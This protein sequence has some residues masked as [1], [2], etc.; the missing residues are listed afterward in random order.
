MSVSYNRGTMSV[1]GQPATNPHAAA[2]LLNLTPDSLCALLDSWG[3]PGYRA[4]QILQ[5]VYENGVASYDPMANLPKRLRVRL[6]EELPIYGSTV[7]WRRESRDG[8]VKLL[9]AW[10]DG[11]TSE[12]V[13]IPDGERRTACLSTQVGCPVGC[14]FCA[15]GLDGLQRQLLAGEIRYEVHQLRRG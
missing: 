15:S 14:V 3:E 6:A 7:A 5:W 13:L 11:A 1:P 4:G 9:L 8:T 10:P 2:G 12:C